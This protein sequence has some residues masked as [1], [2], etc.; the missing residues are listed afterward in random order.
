MVDKVGKVGK[1]SRVGKVGKVGKV[2]RVGKEGKCCA[3]ETFRCFELCSICSRE[4]LGRSKPATNPQC[5]HINTLAFV[6]S[7]C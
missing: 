3:H 6:A 2:G 4:G 7:T 1:V 5:E